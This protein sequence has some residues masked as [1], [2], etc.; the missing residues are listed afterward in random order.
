MEAPAR[1]GDPQGGARA[2]RL[3]L[4]GAE[5]PSGEAQKGEPPPGRGKIQFCVGAPGQNIL[6]EF[7]GDAEDGG[8]RQVLFVLEDAGVSAQAGEGDDAAAAAT[9]IVMQFSVCI[10]CGKLRI[11]LTLNPCSAGCAGA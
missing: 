9:E 8:W 2:G 10:R 11:R 5:L 4:D 3:R 7:A 6:A 1:S